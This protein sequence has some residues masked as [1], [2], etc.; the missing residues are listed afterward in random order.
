MELCLELVP[1]YLVHYTEIEDDC[2]VS[3]SFGY[4]KYNICN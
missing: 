2:F 1:Q 4:S 3:F